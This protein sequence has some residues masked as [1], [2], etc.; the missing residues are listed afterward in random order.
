MTMAASSDGAGDGLIMTVSGRLVDPYRLT[1]TDIDP[2]DLIFGLANACRW[3][4]QCRQ[5]LSVAQHCVELSRLGPRPFERL[6]HDAREAYPP[7]DL[8]SPLKRRDERYRE[9]EEICMLA[10]ADRFGLP[11]GFHRAPD[12]HADDVRIRIDE[13]RLLFNERGD[14]GFGIVLRPMSPAHAAGAFADR[15]FELWRAWG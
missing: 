7:G 14:G 5:F 6:L 3:G 2:E 11:R 1:A 8:P 12:L 4:Q 10:V 9:S 15:F 13:R